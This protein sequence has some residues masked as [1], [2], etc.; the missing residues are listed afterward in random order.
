MGKRGVGAKLHVEL[1]SRT[2]VSS[3]GYKQY[4]RVW[5]FH[6]ILYSV[7]MHNIQ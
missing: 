4:L 6:G 3:H 5:H 2:N 1:I 7:F